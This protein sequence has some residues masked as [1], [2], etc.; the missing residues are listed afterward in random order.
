V[1]RPARA[2][3]VL[4]SEE[5]DIV[6]IAT[7]SRVVLP[8]ALALLAMDSR[9]ARRPA[10]MVVQDAR[11][12]TGDSTRPWADALAVRNGTIVFVGS[13][14][15]VDDLV[16]RR[17]QVVR[18]GGRLVLPGFYDSHAHPL[19][20]ALQRGQ[21]D[22]DGVA[23]LDSVVARVASC[24][25]QRLASNWIQGFGWE[26]SLALDSRVHRG[27]LD[28]VVSDRPVVLRSGRGGQT[29]WVNSVALQR[30]GV[31][32]TTPDPP[33]GRIDRHPVTHE[34]TGLLR[35]SA[36]QLIYRHVPE[37]TDADYDQ[38]VRDAVAAFARVGV[39]AFTDA[40][41]DE[42]SLAA[43]ARADRANRLPLR[44]S[45]AVPFGGGG[46]ATDAERVTQL[47]ALARRYRSSHL[48]IDAV[49][50]HLDGMPDIGTAALVAPYAASAKVVLATAPNGRLNFQTD[51][52][53]RVVA[54]LES[55]GFQVHMHAVGD[56]AVK[57]ALDVIPRGSRHPKG[58][59][60]IAHLFLVQPSDVPRFA[61]L[62]VV[63]NVQ[64]TMAIASAYN[65]KL[66]ESAVGPE[67]WATLHPLRSLVVTGAVVAAGS[68]WPDEPVNPL[69]GIGIAVT[70]RSTD[71]R[72]QTPWHPEQRI[73]LPMALRLYT[74]AGAIQ[75]GSDSEAGSI[76]VGKR[77]D[78]IVL[79][80]NIFEMNVST[81]HQAEVLWTVS[82]GHTVY[83]AGSW[84]LD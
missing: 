43:Y 31:G 59:H 18:L 16:D 77:A 54:A 46:A 80:Q 19:A 34:P 24:A 83:R 64:P 2:C 29:I 15:E 81:V 12:Y 3:W 67:R 65:Q 6:T 42:S 66:V 48:G 74:M 51:R 37:P 69:V 33:S 14:K 20:A 10:D 56:A 1:S 36:R 55:A 62:G 27:A 4:S 7:A 13:L 82:E 72:A 9:V 76:A 25:K 11:I 63:A 8:A 71:P 21:C 26:P 60:V 84:S 78:F 75:A 73:T 22:L 49:K 41:A 39:V 79:A 30:A 52:L 45:A 53:A 44:V 40:F 50:L 23:S 32:A 61:E 35:G 17:T 70:R 47:S 5:D 28:D 68:D 58:R 38:A 57:Q